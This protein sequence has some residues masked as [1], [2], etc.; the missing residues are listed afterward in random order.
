MTIKTILTTCKDEFESLPLGICPHLDRDKMT[1]EEI[2]KCFYT[3]FTKAN[4]KVQLLMCENC[5]RQLKIN[6]GMK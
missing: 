6:H 2:R 4:G 3:S 1:D 5:I